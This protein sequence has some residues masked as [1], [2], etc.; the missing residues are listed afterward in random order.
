[1]V[2]LEQRMYATVRQYTL[3]ALKRFDPEERVDWV[4]VSDNVPSLR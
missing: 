4:L 2:E 3:Q 1:M